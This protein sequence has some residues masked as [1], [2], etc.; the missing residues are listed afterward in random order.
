[1]PRPQKHFVNGR[2]IEDRGGQALVMFALALTTI[3]GFL[4][5]AVDVGLAYS[6]RK[7]AQS[8]ADLAAL[9]GAQQYLSAIGAA[10]FPITSCL[11][12]AGCT[13]QGMLV[14]CP[15]SLPQTSIGSACLYAQKNGFVNGSSNNGYQQTVSVAANFNIINRAPSCPVPQGAA[16]CA[17][18]VTKMNYFVE[19][20]ITEQIPHLFGGVLNMP[21]FNIYASAVAAIIQTGTL[22][23][24]KSTISLVQ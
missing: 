5:L 1:M 3:C 22:T 23:S 18:G 14:T 10:N 9:A 15:A 16:Y 21:V 8:A 4:A 6:I 17:Q 2:R 7:S 19:V 11:A 20:V 24:K 12:T 13:A